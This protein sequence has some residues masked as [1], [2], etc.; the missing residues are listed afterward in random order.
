MVTNGL[1]CDEYPDAYTRLGKQ[2]VDV[3]G[4]DEHLSSIVFSVWYGA[5]KRKEPV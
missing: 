3:V 5:R 4:L 1:V 2:N